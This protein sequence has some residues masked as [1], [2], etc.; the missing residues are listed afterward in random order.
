MST[1][2]GT[3]VFRLCEPVFR[4]G[5]PFLLETKFPRENFLKLVRDENDDLRIYA[6][7]QFKVIQSI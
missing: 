7:S 2:Y 5:N 6:V 1:N 3:L 4:R